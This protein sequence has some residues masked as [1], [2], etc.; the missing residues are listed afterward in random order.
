MFTRQIFWAEPDPLTLQASAMTPKTSTRFAERTAEARRQAE[1]AAQRLAAIVESSDDA[2][3]SKDLNGIITSW[4]KG[5]ERL[6][7]YTEEEAI[8]KP[9]TILIPPERHGEEPAILA[10]IRRGERV[11]PYETVRQRK[12]GNFADISLS[13]S[14]IKS[15]NGQVIGASK[16]ARDITGRKRAEERQ[17]LLLRE[18]SP[19]I[20]NLF[21]IA[22]NIVALSA[23]S[24]PTPEALAQS[25]QERLAAL[26]R[27]HELTLSRPSGEAPSGIQPTTLHTLIKAILLPFAGAGDEERASVAGPDMPVGGAHVTAFALLLHE[28][29]TNAAKY[30][31]LSVP[32]GRIEIQCAEEEGR[33]IL[34]WK[35]RG[36]AGMVQADDAS[37]FGTLLVRATVEHQLAGEIVQEGRPEGLQI[38]LKVPLTPLAAAAK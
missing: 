16:I 21:T 11:E 17:N 26:G 14:P 22:G 13:V 34:N 38:R 15:S 4:N 3:I 12:D 31:A 5:A 10:R 19:R 37:G 32:D 2:V 20:K 33:F 36:A 30:G 7:G 25:V 1:L 23:R 35:E 6:F 8:G 24:A 18:M 28:F 29:A 27:A 9:I